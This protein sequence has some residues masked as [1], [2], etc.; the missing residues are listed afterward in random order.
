[1]RRVTRS[2]ISPCPQ[3]SMVSP[4]SFPLRI[5]LVSLRLEAE[6]G[7]LSCP[8]LVCHKLNACL[9]VIQAPQAPQPGAVQYRDVEGSH[10]C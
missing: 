2:L 1:M 3:F 10:T 5:F 9:R 6:S 8:S 7:P 4:E